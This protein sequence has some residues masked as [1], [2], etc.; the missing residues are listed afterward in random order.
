MRFISNSG[1]SSRDRKQNPASDSQHRTSNIPRFEF[2][3]HLELSVRCWLFL[4]LVGLELRVL[5][6]I[7]KLFRTSPSGILHL[8]TPVIKPVSFIDCPPEH[9][10]HTL[11]LQI[12]FQN[13]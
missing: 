5:S 1:N 3:Q 13:P 6:V 2:R 11:A 9:L 4:E 7:S 10:D 12:V 8:Q